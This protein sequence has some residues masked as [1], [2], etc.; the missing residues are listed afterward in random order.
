M[1]GHL[2]LQDVFRIQQSPP[3]ASLGHRTSLCRIY[4]APNPMFRN[5]LF[6]LI[7]L[8]VILGNPSAQQNPSPS[9]HVAMKNIFYHFNDRITVRI[10]QLD[11][12]VLPTHPN[13]IVIFDD[14]K[15][16]SI[17]I[18]NARISL[19][20]KS[21]A[22][23]LNRGLFANPDAPLKDLQITTEQQKL[24]V[25]GKLHSK[26]DIPFE[27]LG[28]L[29]ATPDG[30]VRIHAEHIKAA[31]L[32]V[33]GLMD[34]LGLDIAK[35]ISNSKVQGVRAEENDLV[36]DP[37][38]ILPLPRITGK[39]TAVQVSGDEVVQTF[40]RPEPLSSKVPGNYMSYRGGE[41]EFGKLTMQN[42]D[43]D[44]IDMDPTDWF[45]FYLDHYR[46]QLSAGYTKITPEFGLRVYMRDYAKLHS[47][48]GR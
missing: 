33:K 14:A 45:D 18:R 32:P 26:G 10:F 35:L 13:S 2:I 30:Y 6:T 24:K 19:S 9:V 17:A 28:T 39:V 20:T 42:S 22:E 46:K 25:K 38:Q 47:A 4:T 7:F 43:M 34:L 3:A 8:A 1:T 21:L 23:A 15:S 48:K 29:A 36:L 31:H 11:G 16:F 40:G 12:A 27:M 44:L 41:L 5:R 37:Q